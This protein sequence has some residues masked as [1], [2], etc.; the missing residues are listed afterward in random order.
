MEEAKRED[1]KK[2]EWRA[3]LTRLTSPTILVPRLATE[4][5]MKGSRE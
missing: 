2:V 3:F 4:L 5:V 1:Q